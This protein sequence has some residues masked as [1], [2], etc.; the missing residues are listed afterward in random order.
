MQVMTASRIELFN[1]LLKVFLFSL[2]GEEK[3]HGGGEP[4]HQE[5]LARLQAGCNIPA[6]KLY[7]VRGDSIIRELF[8]VALFRAMGRGGRRGERGGRA[9]EMP[10]Y[11]NR[12]KGV[13]LSY[14]DELPFRGDITI[15]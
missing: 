6:T 11:F 9:R 13:P 3:L 1:E 2:V 4:E 5:I 14:C 8:F 15:R 10:E 7:T 12:A